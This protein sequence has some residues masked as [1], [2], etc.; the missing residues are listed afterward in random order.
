M[1]RSGRF[2]QVTLTLA[3]TLALAL[4]V[5]LALAL[6]LTLAL[7]LGEA[8]VL[9]RPSGCI[10]RPHTDRVETGACECLWRHVCVGRGVDESG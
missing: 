4:T 1:R 5:A 6:A 3:L 2:G 9:D 10:V 7:T 8:A